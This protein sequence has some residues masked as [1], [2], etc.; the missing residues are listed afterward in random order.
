MSKLGALGVLQPLISLYIFIMISLKKYGE[1]QFFTPVSMEMV[2][3]FD[4]MILS[5]PKHD[6]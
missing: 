5:V 1:T 2:A 6:F 3:T 4:L